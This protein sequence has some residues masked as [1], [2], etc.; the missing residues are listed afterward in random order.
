MRIAAAATAVRPI[1]AESEREQQ[2]RRRAEHHRHAPERHF[3]EGRERVLSA[4]PGGRQ[5]QVV[6]GGTVMVPGIV[7]VFAAFEQVAELDRLVRFVVVHRAHV[8]PG[9]AQRERGRQRDR[10]EGTGDGARHFGK[11]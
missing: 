2:D 5:R 10:D 1:P 7:A 4:E 9:C 8:E 3:I 11:P 6:E